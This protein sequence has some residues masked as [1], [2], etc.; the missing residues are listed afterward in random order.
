MAAANG[1]MAVVQ[2]SAGTLLTD[3]EEELVAE[4]E[5]WEA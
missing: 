1:D 5:N 4:L 3:T 2:Q